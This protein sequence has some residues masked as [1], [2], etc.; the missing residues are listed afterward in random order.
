MEPASGSSEHGLRKKQE[1]AEGRDELPGWG[2]WTASSRDR[3][4]PARALRAGDRDIAGG[5]DASNDMGKT[6]PGFR[7]KGTWFE[8]QGCH[9]LAVWFWANNLTSQGFFLVRQG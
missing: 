4:A 8:S 2:P 1:R 9:F 7:S 6:Q 5:G 3:A